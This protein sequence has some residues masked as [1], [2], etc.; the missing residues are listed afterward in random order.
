MS[1]EL[2]FYDSGFDEL[3]KLLSDYMEK[4]ENPLEI[5]EAGVVE[6]VNDVRKLPR[7]RS[8]MNG[9]GYTHLLDTISYKETGKEV[10][11]GWG[12][13]YGLMLERGTKKMPKG[14][15]HFTPTFENNKEKYYKKMIEKF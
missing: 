10:E 4:L 3:E 5:L 2:D 11:V 1:K 14:V 6:F 9:A 13:Y 7:P 12:K 15:P 8:K